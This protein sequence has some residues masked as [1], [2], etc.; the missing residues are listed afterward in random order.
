VQLGSDP[1]AWS[2]LSEAP[3]VDEAVQKA[4]DVEQA[5]S[6]KVDEEKGDGK[7]SEEKAGAVKELVKAATIFIPKVNIRASYYQGKQVNSI[8][9][10]YSEKKA[11]SLPVLP[12]ALVGLEASDNLGDY[13]TQVNRSQDPFGLP[14]RVMVSLPEGADRAKVGLQTVNVQARYPAGSQAP[15]LNLTVNGG[16]V[17]GENPLPFQYDLKGTAGVEYSADFVFKPSDD[18]Q[19]DTFQYSLSG[20]SERGLITAMAE[21]VV[22]F[23]TINIDLSTDFIWDNADQAVVRLSSAKWQGEKRVVFQKGKEQPQILRIRSN[24]EFQTEPVQYSVDLRK[25]NKSVYTYGPLP[26]LDKQITVVDRF[27]NH[28]PVYFTAGFTNASV[29]VTLTY[30]D[31]D[32]AWEDQFTLE[33]GQKKVQRVIPTLK[34]FRLAKQLQAEYEVTYESGASSKGTIGGASTTIIRP[35][36]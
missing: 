11:K 29:D 9:F 8:D 2:P 31:G 33:A 6:D 1:N 19:T 28:I 21:S 4:K 36:A 20:T 27:V 5:A 24:I 25:A 18:W 23:L 16:T 13:I 35:A 34:D 22:E 15:P 10:L 14:Y 7:D 26:M 17:T 32:F 12:Q 3:K 30:E